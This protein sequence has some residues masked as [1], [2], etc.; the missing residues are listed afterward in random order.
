MGHAFFEV[1][2]TITPRPKTVAIVGADAEFPTT[3]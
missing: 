3:S 2:K 1:A